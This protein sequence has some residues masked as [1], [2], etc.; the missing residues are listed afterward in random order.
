MCIDMAIEDYPNWDIYKT[1]NRDR[2]RTFVALLRYTGMRIG[3]AV[4][5]KRS[6]I[7]DGQ[8]VLRT[9]K[10]GKKVCIPMHP[11]IA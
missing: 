1:N 10:N 2:V 9:E 7:M 11:F 5:L 6:N 4:H 3:D 8:I